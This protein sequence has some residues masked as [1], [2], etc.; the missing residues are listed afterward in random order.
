MRRNTVNQCATFHSEVLLAVRQLPATSALQPRLLDPTA[1]RLV[2][3][4]Q[5]QL[6]PPCSI[7]RTK[8]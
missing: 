8:R 1:K 6:I 7:W 2:V 5:T 3:P 4:A